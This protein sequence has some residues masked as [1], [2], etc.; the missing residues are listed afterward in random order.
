MHSMHSMHDL[1]QGIDVGLVLKQQLHDD[2]VPSAG[3]FMQRA[4]QVLNTHTH[5][6]V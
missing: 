2:Q 1:I 5:T 3:S 6:Q 4:P